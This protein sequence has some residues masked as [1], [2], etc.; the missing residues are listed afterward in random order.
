[1][2]KPGKFLLYSTVAG[3]ASLYLWSA[4]PSEVQAYAYD[5]LPLS[6][7]SSG[8]DV[9]QLQQDLNEAGFH[10][11]D[12]PTDYFGPLTE[13]AVEDFQ[14][15]NGLTVTGEAGRQTIDALSNE[16]TD[17]FRRG[18]SDPAIQDYQEDLN[19]AGF[20]VTN[21]PIAYFGPKTQRAVE[22]FQRA[23][24][25]PSTGILNEE[26]VDA[27][28]YAISSPNSF[29]RGDRHKEV[30]R[31]QELLNKVGFYVTDNPITYFGPKTEGALK[32]FQESFGLPADG[33]AEESTLQL[34]EQEEPGYVKGM[35]HENIQTYQQMLNDAGFHVTDEPSAYFGPLTEQAVEDFQRSYSLPVTGI[36]DDETI[37]VLETASEP[38]EVLKNGV[39]HAS[40]QELQRLL[41]DAGFHVTD[42]PINYFGP[43]TEEALREFQQFYGLEETGTA[44]SE[45]KETLETYIEQSEE[46]LQRGD[47]NDSVEELQ[48][49]LNALGFYVTDAPDTYFDASTEEALQEFQEDQGLPATGMYDV[50]TKETLE[51]L[52]AESF[53]SPF[54]HELQEGYAGENVQLL[55]QHLTAA[56]FETSAGDSFDPDTTARVE[57]YQQERGLS[58]TGRA[59]AATLTS[60]LEM[61]SKT[62]DFYGKDQNGHG[63]GMTQWGAYGM[64]QEGNSYEEILEYYYTDIDVTTSSDYQ[65]RDIRVLLG[66][67]EQ[68][69]ATIESSDSYDI[70]D[71]DGEPVLED[72]EGTTGISYGDDGSGE[73]VITNGD[74]SATTESSISTESD[75]TVQ[76]ED[77]EYRGSLQFKKSDIDGTQSNW[78]MDVVN[79]VDIDDYLEGV[80]PYEM[81]SSWDEPEAFKVQAVAARAYALTQASPESNFDV[82]D[83]TRSQVYHGIPT[84]PQDKPMILDA[85]H[86]TS[87]TVLTY[88][89][90]LVEGIYSA[91][92]SGH[93]EDAEN[94]WGSEF[95]YLTGVEDPYDGSSYAQVSWEESFSTG[96]ISSMEYFQEEDKGDVLALRPVMENERLQEMEV[97]MEEETITLSGD[98]FRSAVDSN[99]ME[100]NIMR[101][102]EKE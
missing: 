72:L 81:Y 25:L 56:G 14:R 12:N 92:A 40:V 31:I 15:S 55:K 63:V 68:H 1:M 79:H 67:T 17:G 93:T 73:F 82:Y 41:N 24:N 69:S 99:E 28:Q 26:T 29:Q 100:S 80:V 98:Q 45:T 97:V 96:D 59:D 66:E 19:T 20:H 87:G 94:V 64:A 70:V 2:F 101:I 16:L 60:L 75:G 5:N 6:E 27:L 52:A 47:T 9:L 50:V 95:D 34:L 88:D 10:V 44:D 48:T 89:G 51:E 38:P 76:H 30:Q 54:E 86:D 83:D 39:R 91:S 65:D 57:E 58:V 18:D 33:V 71:A 11:T 35:K 61:D 13:S 77:T 42:N 37:E 90:Q 53:P 4:A 74:T 49:S 102:E 36:L 21:N 78:V 85:I 8:E 32:D 43:K 23:Y 22:N 3:S 7:T 62:Y 84:G 46:A